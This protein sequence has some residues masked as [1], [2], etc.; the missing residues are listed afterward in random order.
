[1]PQSESQTL[2]EWRSLDEL[3]DYF[4]THDMGKH[5]EK[6]PEFARPM[7]KTGIEKFAR[8][9]GLAQVDLQ[10]LDEAREFFGM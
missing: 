6:M 9:R 7:A 2:P 4:D 3:V 8:D 10:V 5:L 1:M